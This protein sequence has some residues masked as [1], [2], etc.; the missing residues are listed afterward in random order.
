MESLKTTIGLVAFAL[1]TYAYA[2]EL[3]SRESGVAVV[4]KLF[5]AHAPQPLEPKSF[6]EIREDFSERQQRYI[7]SYLHAREGFL[8][9]RMRIASE[10]G[11]DSSS[12][13]PAEIDSRAVQS[14]L[15]RDIVRD[16][17]SIPKSVVFST[18]RT[19]GRQLIVPLQ[20]TFEEYGQDNYSGIGLKRTDV[21]L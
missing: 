6:S 7:D 5:A 1:T 8:V 17:S 10:L 9:T 20:E 2:N 21:I 16:R 3:P 18:A 11:A 15:F 12:W 19:A 13:W 4:K 14:A